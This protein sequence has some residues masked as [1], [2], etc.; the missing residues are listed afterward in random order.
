MAE[1]PVVV[2]GPRRADGGWWA[3]L[4]SAEI[5]DR[6]SVTDLLT[7]IEQAMAVD[8]PGRPF[9]LVL[10]PDGEPWPNKVPTFAW[11]S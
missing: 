3:L 2:F 5:L 7:A 1:P 9:A 4:P 10:D 8:H 6:A 11:S